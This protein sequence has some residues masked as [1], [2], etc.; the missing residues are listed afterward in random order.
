MRFNIHI[1]A[2]VIVLS[3]TLVSA[4]INL[5]NLSHSIEHQ[6]TSSTPLRGWLNF[7]IS[8]EPGNTLISAFD[9]NI[10]LQEL[11]NENSISC[12]I[13]NP[14]ECT[15]FPT[16]CEP[17]FSTI[18]I[19]SETKNYDLRDFETKL[20]G[21]KITEN[22]SEI[23]NFRFNISTNAQSSCTNP[24]MIDLFDDGN[25]EFKSNNVSEDECF[26]S[27]PFGCFE[28]SEITQISPIGEISLCEKIMVPP[29]RGF[30]I[31]A[32]IIGNQTAT[33]FMS[34]SIPSLEGP[35]D[36]TISNI[37][38]SGEVFCRVVLETDIPEETEAEVCIY[39]TEGNIN[40]Y[41]I[42]YEDNNTCGYIN[43]N[44]KTPHDFEI[45]AKP[46][47]YASPGDVAFSDNLFDEETNISINVFDYL[48]RRYKS[49]CGAGC[50]IPIRV[51]SGITQRVSLS[52]LI[53]DYN[54]GG[55]NPPGSEG[56]KFEDIVSS[57]ALFTSAF[58]KYD[59]EPAN[60]LVPS[61]SNVT[62]F[63][64]EIGDLSIEG[65]I[66]IIKIPKI[67]SIIPLRVSALVP[68]KFFAIINE[69]GNLTYSW[70]FG[71]NSQTQTSNSN[72]IEH[73]YM[74][75]GSFPLTVNITNELG[76]T[77][78]T[79]FVNVV[80]P[81]EAINE[82][83]VDY[84]ARLKSID[85]NLFVLPDKLQERIGQVLDTADLKSAI[86]RIE[87][88]YKQLFET[89]SEDLIKLMQ[90]LNELKVPTSFGTS[91]EIKPSKF[92]QGSSRIDLDLIGEF[93]AGGVED[94]KIDAYSS[95]INVWMDENLDM[96][97]ESKSY[98]F[99]F[100][101]GTE[102]TA[103]THITLTLNPKRSIGEFYMIIE[104]DTNNIR[105][106]GDYSEKEINPENIGITFR[107][108]EPESESKIEFLYPDKIEALNPPVYISPEFKFL[109][110]GFSAGACNNNGMCEAGED[111]NNCRADCKPIT[112]TI[113]ILVILFF[114]AFIVYIVLQE[115]YKRN[116]QKHLFKSPNELF[117]LI[118]FMNSGENQKL[119]KDQ[120]F[121]QLSQ[122]KW[123]KEQL[124]YAWNK[125][126]HKRTGMFEIPILR[127]FEK[128]KLKKE[129][130]KRRSIGLA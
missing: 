121:K 83:I 20:L 108:L 115:W 111:Y 28:S 112:R 15:C 49:K 119:S 59:L 46:L 33:L 2:L 22:I 45:F 82:T 118:N 61:N 93:G 21:V 53:I 14:Y 19:A 51:Y 3:L 68:T 13:V 52:E 30:N 79:L 7:S 29:V 4:S 88:Q 107:D 10:T 63:E 74:T 64:L 66:S 36:C 12:N 17:A 54:L 1:I 87:E 75:L 40:K 126:H 125:L 114:L 127:P 128:R 109:E 25:I 9:S 91:L 77:A 101:D 99:H 69:P 97:I 57:P 100:V 80:A 103:L 44:D 89:E 24:L 16:D 48:N 96:I 106:L 56:N 41:S 38:S 5:G 124:S 116:Y 72:I 90:Q 110:L 39:A 42:R 23:T 11:M 34:F 6:Y 130:A 120:I 105:L 26:I 73:T 65:N 122:R 8:N 31:G 76:T 60:L 67:L 78:K 95:G 85:N 92:I 27:K 58:I 32:N 117:N 129:L 37:N 84:R 43:N 50:I 94:N 98:S 35:E 113:I 62:D 102:Q 71:D 18:N 70:N 47:K 104:G 81:F 55:L 86:N 123:K